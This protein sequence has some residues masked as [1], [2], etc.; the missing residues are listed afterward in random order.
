MLSLL[1]AS[2][3]TA[4]MGDSQPNIS[5][6]FSPRGGTYRARANTTRGFRGLH[7]HRGS[8]RQSGQSRASYRYPT[9]SPRGRGYNESGISPR[10][11][12]SDSRGKRSGKS[13]VSHRGSSST[14][15]AH[16]GRSQQR[17]LARVG[18]KEGSEWADPGRGTRDDA[19]LT[20]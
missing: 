7:E 5:S 9:F 2:T 18:S 11:H 6:Y 8:W 3:V 13:H 10:P 19:R 1:R 15:G 17:P 4:D 14:R 16:R 20:P 12:E